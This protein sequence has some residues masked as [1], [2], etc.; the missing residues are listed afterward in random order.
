ME[1]AATVPA[2]FTPSAP[3]NRIEGNN[4]V[5]ADRGLDV[6]VAGN[7]L[8]KNTSSGNTTDWDVV[9]GNVCLVVQGVAG[10]AIV[11]NSGGGCPGYVPQVPQGDEDVE[12]GPLY[13]RFGTKALDADKLE[14]RVAKLMMDEDVE[15]RRASTPTYSTV[16]RST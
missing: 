8:V 7:I 6:D 14:K 1:T 5:G 4:C 13:G 15:R 10:A 2:T 3:D 12:W 11:G 9:A 16:T